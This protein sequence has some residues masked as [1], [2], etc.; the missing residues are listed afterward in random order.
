MPEQITIGYIVGSGHSG[1]TLTDLLLGSQPDI[2]SFGEMK[3]LVDV[4][5][6][7]K[8]SGRCTCGKKL[9]D[10]HTWRPTLDRLREKALPLK[11]VRPSHK[12]FLEV[13]EEIFASLSKTV[14]KRILVDS[15]KTVKRMQQLINL[16]SKGFDI[17]VIHLIRDGRAVAFSNAR[18]GRSFEE[19]IRNWSEKNLQIEEILSSEIPSLRIHYEQ[20]VGSPSSTIRKIVEFL[21]SNSASSPELDW[22]GRIRH[23]VGGN[24]MR[25]GGSS[26]IKRDDEYL[27]ATT[28]QEW[29]AAWEVFGQTLLR[30]GYL[31]SKSLPHQFYVK[32]LDG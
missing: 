7:T 6:G 13:N 11:A 25:F 21:G 26:E 12:D 19:C 20:V 15:S 27:R 17:R 31:Q 8:S 32:G 18:K 4:A 14:G 1:S 3:N 30:F 5:S 22:A 2:S 9:Y 23:N 29:N 16:K 24:R 10:C 28:D